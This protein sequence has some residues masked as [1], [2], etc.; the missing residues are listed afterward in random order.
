MNHALV[1]QGGGFRTAY[2]SGVLDAFMELDYF[3]FNQIVAVSGG[4]IAASYYISR[5]PR[6]CFNSICFLAEKGRFVN[7]SGVFRSRPLMD[8]D[9]FHAISSTHFPF[10]KTAALRHLR[11]KQFRIVMTSRKSGQAFYCDP[12][13]CQWEEAVIASCSLPF[14]TKGEQYILG[15]AYMDGAWSD[16]LPVEF[17]YGQ[18]AR[19]ITVVRTTPQHEKGTKTWF[20]RVGELYYRNHLPLKSTFSDN[21]IYFNKAIEFLNHPPA[22]LEVN[23][24]AP[25][26]PLKAG[27]YTTSKALLHEDYHQGLEAGR[28]FVNQELSLTV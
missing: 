1:I 3:P 15:E 8:V 11:D 12:T 26:T 23:Q 7:I 10:D 16:P 28:R 21:H 19:K 13:Q 14:I 5:Q 24:I 22:D 9:I 25:A 2:S 18:G 20:D 17:A 4:A 27:L 6:N